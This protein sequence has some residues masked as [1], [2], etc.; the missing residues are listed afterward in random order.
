MSE[1]YKIGIIGLGYVGLPLAVEFASKGY[2]VLG[3]DIKEKRIEA[4]QNHVDETD[5]ITKEEL[6][7]VK[8]LTFS[9]DETL[10][11]DRDIYII[12][13]PTP[14]D[15]FKQPDLDPLL[16]SSATVGKYLTKGDV[17]IYESTT[18]PGCT[19]EDCVPVLESS[20]GLTFNE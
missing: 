19:E 1:K 18:Y 12:T 11:K 10:L 6:Q 15:D 4:L 20:S 2:D 16:K 8:T 13:V 7:Q 9:S 17:V 5:E 14:V 3:F